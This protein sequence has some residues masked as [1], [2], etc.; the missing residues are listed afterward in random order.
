MVEIRLPASLNP[1]KGR[2]SSSSASVSLSD[3]TSIANVA[4]I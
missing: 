1:N 3:A 2:F 4:Q